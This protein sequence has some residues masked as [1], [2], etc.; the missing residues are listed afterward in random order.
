MGGVRIARG[1]KLRLIKLVFDKLVPLR[2]PEWDKMGSGRKS[3]HYKTR[4][5]RHGLLNH[6]RHA[7]NKKVEKSRRL[8]SVGCR[9]LLQFSVCKLGVC[10]V[11]SRAALHA[12][13]QRARAAH[14]LHVYLALI[15]QPRVRGSCFGRVHQ[16]VPPRY[17]TKVTT[18]ARSASRPP[19]P[20][21]EFSKTS[22]SCQQL[23]NDRNRA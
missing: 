21:L 6:A 1:H 5:S 8:S 10:T 23:E 3:A 9:T 19:A 12:C 11:C 20:A 22:D 14:G 2:F 16:H 4:H 17:P 18:G 7:Q 13:Q 15:L